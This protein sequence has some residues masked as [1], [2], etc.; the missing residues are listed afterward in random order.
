MMNSILGRFHNFSLK[1]K[2]HDRFQY[3]HG[4]IQALVEFT[5]TM[6][7]R[8]HEFESQQK[9]LSDCYDY[10]KELV[11]KQNRRYN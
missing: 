3:I 9:L 7:K 2:S 11:R 1:L 10:T 4:N 5:S 8:L 6:R